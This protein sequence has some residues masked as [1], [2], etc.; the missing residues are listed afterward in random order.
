MTKGSKNNICKIKKNIALCISK[1]Y[2]RSKSYYSKSRN[3]SKF[4]GVQSEVL[5]PKANV[6][7]NHIV[8][9]TS[10]NAKKRIPLQ[11]L[12]N[13]IDQEPRLKSSSNNEMRNN[14]EKIIKKKVI[15]KKGTFKKNSS[16]KDLKKK[17]MEN[18]PQTFVCKKITPLDL[19]VIMDTSL[20]EHSSS[21]EENMDRGNF[22]HDLTCKAADLFSLSNSQDFNE[23][24]LR[25]KRNKNT[26]SV[27]NLHPGFGL[28]PQTE[29]VKI[30][31]YKMKSKSEKDKNARKH[32]TRRHLNELYAK[33]L[34]KIKNHNKSTN[35]L[36]K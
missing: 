8:N 11:Q 36:H 16:L 4:K 29:Q 31:N 35:N 32:F 34:I 30:R 2:P 3:G 22:L 20:E 23:G 12:T 33:V 27:A 10:P 21:D 13:N 17:P 7:L 24:F 15:I 1:N 28:K 5:T 9:F 26:S 19:S 14:M 25:Y 6:A 18:K